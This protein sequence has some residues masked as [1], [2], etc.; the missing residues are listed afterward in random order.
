MT[1][2]VPTRRPIVG[3]LEGNQ[4]RLLI[5]IPIVH[6]QSDMGSYS[7]DL[8]RAYI[9]QKGLEAWLQSR[10]AISE[11]WEKLEKAILALD[12]DYDRVR[13]YQDGLPVCGHETEIIRD[14]AETGGPNYRI[15]LQ[16]MARGAALEG[17]ESPELLLQEYDLLKAAMEGPEKSIKQ[18][19]E[20]TSSAMKKALIKARDRFT[21][22]R[23]DTTLRPGEIG[24]L[25]LGALHDA[26]D[27]LPRTIQ[28]VS[29]DQLI[30]TW[31]LSP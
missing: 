10:H 18:E 19:P 21:A 23:I 31:A 14:L 2:K 24:M 8:R 13:L 17:T 16:L 12:L 26:I 9:Q 1:K 20:E 29:L 25:F 27:L 7:E 5:H 22:D 15:L 4:S 6:S 28:V 30:P 11:F 3:Q